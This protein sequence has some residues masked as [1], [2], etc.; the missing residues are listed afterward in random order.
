[1]PTISVSSPDLLDGFRT[2]LALLLAA[3]YTE[4]GQQYFLSPG[5]Q[6]KA[7]LSV[8]D[9]RFLALN[10]MMSPTGP[11]TVLDGLVTDGDR[12]AVFSLNFTIEP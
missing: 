7:G 4:A 2:K 3:G 12:N 11:L 9:L 6:Q 8:Q 5:A 10:P 1:M